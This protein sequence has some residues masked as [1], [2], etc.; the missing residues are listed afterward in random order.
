M[1]LRLTRLNNDYSQ[2]KKYLSGNPCI[3]LVK[4][5]GYP[6][7]KYQLKYKIRSIQMEDGQI[8]ESSQH[9]VEI[10]LPLDYPAIQPQCRML[11]PVFHPNIAPH[12]ICI[13]DHWAAGES[14]KD[15]VIRIGEMLC[16]QNYSIKSPLN[17][18]AAKWAYSNAHR[19][20]FEVVDLRSCGSVLLPGEERSEVFADPPKTNEAARC[21]N[22]GA[23][24][25]SAA[26]VKC[27]NN[28][29]LCPDC[30][31]RCE[32][33]GK[34]LC[35]ICGVQKCNVCGRIICTDCSEVCELCRKPV[36][37]VHIKECPVCGRIRCSK[38]MCECPECGKHYCKIHF[39]QQDNICTSCYDKKTN[40]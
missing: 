2:I 23:E 6:P 28:H 18:E 30:V 40:Q 15:V 25:L 35:I 9:L 38:C 13:A 36:C 22:C 3:E 31:V 17:G 21:S 32:K 26:A 8:K 34:E 37:R 10:V 20:P 7:E 14:L 4:V 12:A 19:F 39:K 33:C 16:Y 29:L 1:N 24:I 11:T 5:S 27:E